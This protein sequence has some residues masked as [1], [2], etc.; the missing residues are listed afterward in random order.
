[1]SNAQCSS[2]D[3]VLSRV[4]PRRAGVSPGFAACGTAAGG[5]TGRGVSDAPGSLPASAAT[6]EAERLPWDEWR[7]LAGAPDVVCVERT[8]SDPAPHLHEEFQLSLVQRPTA[9]TDARGQSHAALPRTL[10][11]V[12]ALELHRDQPLAGGGDDGWLIRELHIGAAVLAD[13]SADVVGGGRDAARGGSSAAA[14]RPAP[15]FSAR[16]VDDAGLSAAFNGLYDDMRADRGDARG[17]LTAPP[18]PTGASAIQRESRLLSCLATLVAQYADRPRTPAPVMRGDRGVRLAREYLHAHVKE[19]VALADLA[20]VAGLS[21]FSLIRAF[22]RAVGL[23]P[24]AYHTHLRLARARHLIAGGAPLSDV[25]FDA[26]FADQSHLTRRFK[27]LF[28]V[29]PG[30]YARSRV[31]VAARGGRGVVAATGWGARSPAT[32]S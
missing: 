16:V 31:R 24:H 11:V 28:G 6:H 32:V 13:V 27:A 18:A 20:G 21:K 5:A 26:G 29:T 23:P 30:Q 17:S 8:V 1:M 12:N 19:H 4:L 15:W 22:E 14:R 10:L 2:K 7:P 9:S 3:Q 25:A